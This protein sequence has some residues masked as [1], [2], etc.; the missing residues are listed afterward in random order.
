MWQMST[1]VQI[2]V[3]VGALGVIKKGTEKH[4]RVIPS[5]NNQQEIQRIGTPCVPV[6]VQ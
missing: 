2:P 1:V 6:V 5:N 4:L 3:V